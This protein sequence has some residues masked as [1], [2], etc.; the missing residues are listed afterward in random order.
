MSQTPEV[1]LA[2]TGP[3]IKDRINH[4]YILANQILTIQKAILNLENSTQITQEAV[5]GLIHIIPNL[6]KDEQ[7]ENELDDA[8]KEEDVDIRPQFCG[9]KASFAFCQKHKLET[10]KKR[11]T[12]EHWKGL[13]TC[14]NLL[15]RRGMIS[16][17]AYKEIMTGL[18]AREGDEDV[19]II[20]N[21]EP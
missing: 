14:I 20:E 11:K 19:T 18:P 4:P 3:T 12:L 8:Y 15:D 6:W 16:K 10:T 5:E 2:L 1:T 17:R 13:Q 7:Y 9:N 21:S